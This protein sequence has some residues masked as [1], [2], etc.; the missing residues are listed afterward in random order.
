MNSSITGGVA[1]TPSTPNNSTIA[2]VAVNSSI[3]G[4][5]TANGKVTSLGQTS[6]P[7]TVTVAPNS[8]Y[9]TAQYVV[10][11]ITTNPPSTVN[12]SAATAGI[13]TGWTN[14]VVSAPASVQPSVTVQS[15]TGPYQTGSYTVAPNGSVTGN[16]T[17]LSGSALTFSTVSG[18]GTV[19]SDGS[20]TANVNA[21][22]VTSV[23]ATGISTGG[24]LAVTGAT[25]LTGALTANG[26]TTTTTLNVTG[27]ST[28]NGITNT[29]N[30]TNS[31]AVNTATLNTTG[32]ASVGGALAVTGAST[33]NGVTNTGNITNSGAVNTATLNTTGNASVG[34]AL[35]VTGASTTNGITNTGN[36]TNSGA[37]NTATLSTT[38]NASVGG[39]L[40]V[41]GASTTNGI[42]NTGNITNSGAVNTATLNVSGATSTNGIY[43][44]NARISGVANGTDSNDAVNYGQLQD[45]RKILSRGI[46]SVTAMA[47]IPAVDQGKTFSVGLGLGNY[48]S[49]TAVALGASYR[50]GQVAVLRGSVAGGNGGKTA[51]GVGIG[52]SW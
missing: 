40:A 37:V 51:F 29:G 16:A 21:T 38:G 47:N 26:G 6:Q 45:T 11:D 22:T 5:S 30:I 48:D 36:I 7:Y 12:T 49:S 4:A 35:A 28:T 20:V 32:N 27:A 23:S 31:G 24:T 10:Q 25:T 9:A 1:T 8:G 34:G 17:Q 3:L 42:A 43:N 39:K 2:N 44:N 14:P 50:L 33:T 15:N 41:T 13:T 52:G 19:N 46:A 18:T